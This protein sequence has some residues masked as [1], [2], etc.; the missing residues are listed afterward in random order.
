[1]SFVAWTALASGVLLVMALASSYVRRL[2]ITMAALCLALGVALGPAVTGLVVLDVREY[3]IY[4][5]RAA[6]IGVIV[7][8]FVSGLKLRLGWR[9]PAW[10]AA[11]WLA[12][13]AMVLTIAGV[14][15]L[16]YFALGLAPAPALLLG[17]ILAPTDPVLA[18]EVAVTD[19]DD[20]DRL[21]YGLSGEAGLNDGTAFPFVVL[22]LAWQ[23][24]GG[25]GTWLVEW[26]LVRLVWAIPAA[27]VLGYGMGWSIGRL[28]I[29]LR[30]RQRDNTAPSDLFALALIGLS[31]VSADAIGAWGFLSVFAAGLGLRAAEVSVV[32][33][34]PHPDAPIEPDD[35]PLDHPP[36]EVLVEARVGADALEEPAVAAGVLVS[37]TLSFG[38]TVERLIG[39]LLTVVIGIAITTYWDWRAIPLALILFVVI[40]PLAVRA[41][42]TLTPTTTAQRWLMGW[43]G[44]RGIGSL[45]Y[46]AYALRHG[47]DGS[48]AS[49]VMGMVIS[50]VGLS[51]VVHGATSTP[52]LKRYERA[53]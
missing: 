6:E 7:A 44:I 10:R 2:P 38:D 29:R 5:E 8:L 9:D 24:S 27:L 49:E 46:L 19:A 36:A 22:A 35:D 20:H 51:I 13:P 53:L 18:G 30:N 34:S 39:V 14:A 43:F 26:A 45:Y 40:R 4:L 33:R 17:A 3:A 50:V 41:C 31:Y 23:A 52:L 48:A 21:R 32:K 42:L 37:E 12:G 28:A 47:G 11:M 1:M 15:A 16:G 25:A